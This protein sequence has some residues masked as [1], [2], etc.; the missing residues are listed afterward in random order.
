MGAGQPFHVVCPPP[1]PLLCPPCCGVREV[2]AA[3]KAAAE[4]L[5]LGAAGQCG[6]LETALSTP[7]TPLI[8]CEPSC[9]FLVYVHSMFLDEGG[10]LRTVALRPHGIFGP[11]DTTFLPRLVQAARVRLPSTLPPTVHMI[12]AG[13]FDAYH[14]PNTRGAFCLD[15]VQDKKSS[16]IIGS[17][18]CVANKQACIL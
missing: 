14:A 3:T 18:K 15:C 17:G 1:P 16:F 5:V 9:S 11:G 2:Y 13:T 8:T 4:A 12:C 10:A 7:P 6:A